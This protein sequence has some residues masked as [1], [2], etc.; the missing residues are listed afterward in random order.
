VV[1]NLLQRPALILLSF[2]L[3]L[4]QLAQLLLAVVVVAM[5]T[6]VGWLALVDVVVALFIQTIGLLLRVNH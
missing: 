5:V 3:E 6:L 2:Q 1:R 4:Q